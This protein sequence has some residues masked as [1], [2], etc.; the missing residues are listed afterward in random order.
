MTEFLV[1][2]PMMILLWAGVDYFRVAY[3]IRLNTLNLSHAEAWEKAYSN[4]GTCFAGGKP[5]DGFT[6]GT[7]GQNPSSGLPTSKNGDTLTGGLTSSLIM[8]NIATSKKSA[9]VTSS[10]WTATVASSTAVTCDEVVPK[11]DRD[12]VAPLADLIKSIL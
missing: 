9:T 11:D 5:W 1:G 10:R 12:V 3:A 4:D 6:K 8:Y 7:N 2:L